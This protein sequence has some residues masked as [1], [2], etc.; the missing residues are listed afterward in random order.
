MRQ[1]LFILGRSKACGDCLSISVGLGADAGVLKTEL[2]VKRAGAGYLEMAT[3]LR[4][5][6]WP[7][8]WGHGAGH[9]PGGELAVD[10]GVGAGRGPWGSWPCGQRLGAASGPT[11]ELLCSVL[12]VLF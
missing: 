8:T 9:G 1:N 4:W 5:G 10:L 11:E 3:D 12:F 6:S 7:W 2:S